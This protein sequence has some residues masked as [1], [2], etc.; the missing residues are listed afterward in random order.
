VSALDLLVPKVRVA[1][2]SIGVVWCQGLVC[3]CLR[4]V[5]LRQVWRG[6]WNWIFVAIIR[7]WVCWRYKLTS[8]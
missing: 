3:L 8:L 7:L 1:G 5:V 2:R 6:C 4:C